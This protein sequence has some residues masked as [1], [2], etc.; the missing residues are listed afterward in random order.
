MCQVVRRQRWRDLSFEEGAARVI[1]LNEKLEPLCKGVDG[2]FSGDISV[3]G[4]VSWQF[5]PGWCTFFR[6][7]KLPFFLEYSRGHDEG[8]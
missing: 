2:M 1:A 3:S 4:T 7:W 8:G 6:H 5:S